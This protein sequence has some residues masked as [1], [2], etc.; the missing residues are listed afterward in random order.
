MAHPTCFRTTA[1][2][3]RSLIF[4]SFGKTQ[5]GLLGKDRPLMRHEQAARAY[6]LRPRLFLF[7]SQWSGNRRWIFIGHILPNSSEIYASSRGESAWP[8]V[9]TSRSG[10]I[11]RV[12]LR[13][14][15][16]LSESTV[17]TSRFAQRMGSVRPGD[18]GLLTPHIGVDLHIIDSACVAYAAVQES[19]D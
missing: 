7:R 4:T 5:G 16:S 19:E 15:V 10:T 12:T 18:C 13:P 2:Q 9:M 17:F 3:T 6:C 8:H 1:K 11:P 14:G